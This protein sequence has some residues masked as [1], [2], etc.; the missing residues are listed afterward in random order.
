MFISGGALNAFG[1]YDITRF[2][3]SVFDSDDNEL[4]VGEIEVEEP[5]QNSGTN[6]FEDIILPF[7][8]LL[9]CLKRK[10]RK[11]RNVTEL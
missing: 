4:F 6:T 8:S 5:E 2:Q 3:V 9:I 11:E 7:L 10:A 1:T